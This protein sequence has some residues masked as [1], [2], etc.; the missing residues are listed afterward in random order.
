MA[1]LATSLADLHLSDEV[2]ARINTHVANA[3]AAAQPQPTSSLN[4]HDQARLVRNDEARTLATVLKPTKPKPYTGAIDA[5]ACL[6]FIDNQEEYFNIVD[7]HRDSWV[8]YTAVS[9]EGDAKAWWRSSGLKLDSTWKAF[10]AA[11]I[12]YHTP[13]NAVAAA[14]Q[15]LNNLR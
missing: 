9:L 8:K 2:L 10:E 7:L 15:E 4:A 12:A 14:R 5:D 6:N 3:V 1:E 13:P 11:F